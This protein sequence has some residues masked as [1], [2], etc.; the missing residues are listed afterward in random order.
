MNTNEI[1][2]A[3]ITGSINPVEYINRYECNYI[4]TPRLDGEKPEHYWITRRD[5]KTGEVWDLEP[6]SLPKGQVLNALVEYVQ[7][8]LQTVEETEDGGRI[9]TF[10]QYDANEFGTEIID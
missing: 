7:N 10:I 6:E 1:K 4:V 8:G 3:I 2:N 5:V 9:L